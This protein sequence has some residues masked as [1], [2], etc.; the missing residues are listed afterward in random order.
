MTTLND[1]KR[2]HASVH[3]ETDTIKRR[4]VRNLCNGN[5]PNTK[6]HPSEEYRQLERRKVCMARM[7][8][9][10]DCHYPGLLL[11]HVL[12]YQDYS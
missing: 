12:V 6:V 4:V 2:L 7:L 10:E 8:A 1:L 9:L 3:S 11:S 5:H